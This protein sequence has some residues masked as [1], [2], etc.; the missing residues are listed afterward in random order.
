MDGKEVLTKMPQS[1]V[2][3][4]VIWTYVQSWLFV[5]TGRRYLTTCSL[6]QMR[7]GHYI[8]MAIGP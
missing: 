7:N 5:Q 4:L 6:S 1:F 3:K 8:L 2:T